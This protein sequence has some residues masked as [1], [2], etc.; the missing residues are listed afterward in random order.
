LVEAAGGL[1]ASLAWYHNT[2]PQVLSN[3]PPHKTD[4]IELLSGHSYLVTPVRW[5]NTQLL[6]PGWLPITVQ[7]EGWPAIDAPV[8]LTFRGLTDWA[9]PTDFTIDNVRLVTACQ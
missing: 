1:A 8:Y 3:Q 7:I 9:I 4:L 5:R 6:S 2:R